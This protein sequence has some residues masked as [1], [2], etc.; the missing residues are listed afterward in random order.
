MRFHLTITRPAGWHFAHCFDEIAETLVHGLRALGHEVSF[1][2]NGVV[3]GAQNIILGAHLC[4]PDMQ[5]PEGT[6]LYNLEQIGG[7]API[8]PELAGRF[9]IWDFSERNLA[10]WKEHGI[11]AVHVPIGFVPQLCRFR[12]SAT[13]DIDVLFYGSLS[14][15]REVIL[16]ELRQW[17][18]FNVVAYQG[19][20][21]AR[22]E[23]IA[24]AKVVLNM[25]YYD[26][27]HLFEWP[28]VS[29]LLANKKAVVSETSEDDPPALAGGLRIV[30]HRGL[31]AACREL[32]A[33][34]A[35]RY[36]LE[37]AG[38]EAFRKIPETDILR[39]A[40]AGL[41]QPPALQ[42]GQ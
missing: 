40:L 27:P 23:Q 9:P 22:D 17:A 4:A 32:V 24:R 28:R 6:I 25:H 31:V 5:L 1:Q 10:R 34:R 42:A 33:D 16:G 39:R 18:A 38:Y 3:S 20:G 11:E 8:P 12:P 7:G 13:Q 37:Q 29:Y 26:K 2:A 36:K 19:F 30:P 14:Q 35:S 41:A 21:S 15:R